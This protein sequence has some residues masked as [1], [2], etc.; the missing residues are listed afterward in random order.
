M[1]TPRPAAIPPSVT[2][3]QVWRIA[4]PLM[5]SNVSIPLLG[6]VDT[7]VV[8]QLPGAEN[9]G[10]VAV[11]ALVINLIYWSFGFLRMGTSGYTAQAFGADDHTGLRTTL[12][13]GLLIATGAGLCIVVLQEPIAWASMALMQPSAAVSD[14]AASYLMIRL[15]GAPFTLVIYVVHGWLLGLQ[16]TRAVLALQIVLNGTNIIL[17]IVFV[18]GFGWG[19]EGVAVATIASEALAAA[20]GIY[21]IKRQSRRLSGYWDR[22]AIKAWSGIRAMFGVNRD[23]FIR[24]ACLQAAALSFTAVGARLGDDILAANAVLLLF[25]SFM[26][27]ALDGLADAA[28]ALSGQAY[29]A[30]NV[31]RFW[32][33]VRKTTVWS[34][35]FAVVFSAVYALS[36]PAIVNIISAD[37]TV[38][39][40]AAVYLPY[41]VVLPLITVWSF[42]LDGVF[43]GLTRGQDLRNAMVVSIAC[44][45]ALLWVLLPLAGNHGLWWAFLGFQIIRALALGALLPRLGRLFL[46]PAP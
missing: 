29:G 13:R 32:D 37:D 6:I 41:V 25:F 33:A 9:I 12:G 31:E 38:R 7:A 28:N 26:A 5:V 1:N 39:A 23:L 30:R 43:I 46:T 3:G 36:G 10:A 17:D 16:N 24:T 27:Y 21:L 14:L 8:G 44:F 15:W 35:G 22:T 34:I 40:T 4:G 2:H 45:G 19:V 11:G 18:L 42:E 20:L